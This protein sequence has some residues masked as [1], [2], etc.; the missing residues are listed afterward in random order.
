MRNTSCVI[1]EWSSV[2]IIFYEEL[3]MDLD[4]IDLIADWLT[5]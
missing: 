3:Q 5:P 2:G 4:K 1:V